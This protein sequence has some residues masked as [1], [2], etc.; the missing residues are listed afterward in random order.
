PG[1]E[2]VADK[3]LWKSVGVIIN[4]EL[5]TYR[6]RV[7]RTCRNLE[8]PER[9]G[10]PIGKACPV[11]G[12]TQPSMLP[13]LDFNYVDPDGFTTDLTAE[14]R[15]AGVRVEA[16]VNRSRSFLLAE[17]EQISQQSIPAI[18][19]ARLSYS[20][21]REG[22]L[23]ALNSGDQDTGFSICERCG[24]QAEPPRRRRGQDQQAK[25]EHRTPGGQNCSGV[26]GFYHLGHDFK[27]DTLHLQFS[28]TAN[29]TLPSG[30]DQ[31]FWLSLNYALL[32]GASLALQIERRDLDGVVRPFQINLTNDP[33]QNYSQEIVLF[34]NVPGGAGHMRHISDNLETV[35][36]RALAVVQCPDCSTE[37]SCNSCLRGYD[38]QIYWEQLKRGQVAKFLES[39]IVEAF[40]EKLDHLAVGASRVPAVDKTRWLAQQ[41][42]AAGQE[43]LLNVKRITRERPQG[44]T[45]NWAEIIQE[46]LRRNV[47][48]SLLLSE[49]PPHDCSRPE[50]AGLRNYLRLL[51]QDY[52]LKLFAA[53]SPTKQTWHMVID[54][55]GENCRAIRLED[56]ECA[57]RSNTGTG[58]MITT[59]N[60]D[61]VTA[62]VA[63]I[64]KLPRRTVNASM[65][66]LPPNV[67]ILRTR[68][69]EQTTEAKLFGEL[70]RAPLTALKVNDR[71]LRSDHHEKRLRAYLSLIAAPA[72]QRIKVLIMTWPAEEQPSRGLHYQTSAEQKGMAA[73]LQQAFP[74]IDL[75]LRL[76]K[77]LP[78]D[79]FLE[80][81][82]AD[83]T[84]ARIGIG[85]GLDFIKANGRACTTD[86][87]IEDPVDKT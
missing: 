26:L 36:R 69:G 76:E 15:K 87:I 85:A 30:N 39:L 28:D 59:S 10:L 5:K 51:V 24:A 31:S 37:T 49:L 64:N 72:G 14:L 47:K 48:V 62:I 17:G 82:R 41:L 68:D 19:A 80:L 7:C 13:G 60:Q 20:Y 73:R 38:N 86:I 12:D 71:Y 11:C 25:P 61:A 23:V 81:T 46:L 34:D 40:P 4:E 45:R 21:R 1:A 29:V 83:G 8:H 67:R 6:Y 57:L 33:S 27:T 84:R 9:S 44:E 50:L 55:A 53:E 77:R 63:T 22:R 43:V 2:V 58:G 79:R 56:D 54:P 65:L 52:G 78:H 32:Q 42:M 70:F 3:H 16:A 75:Q 18:G 35:F 74:Q 66:E